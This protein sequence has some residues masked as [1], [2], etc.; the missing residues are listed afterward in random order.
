[1]PAGRPSRYNADFARMARALSRHGA[2]AWDLARAFSVSLA[3]FY[4]WRTLHP[5]FAPAIAAGA[6]KAE[7]GSPTAFQRARGYD[8]IE[9]RV[10]R[11]D[12]SAP[13]EVAIKRRVLASP[14]AAIRWLRN[15][16]PDEWRIPH[17]PQPDLLGLL[18]TETLKALGS[19]CGVAES[20]HADLQRALRRL[21][22]EVDTI[23]LEH[24]RENLVV[25]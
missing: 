1:M 24:T 3:T 10:F 7:H 17:A 15:R 13:V 19:L 4:R 14:G 21:L 22:A 23:L 9:R 16:R 11:P 12:S 2:D 6:A 5:E 8:R 18:G 25:A 20:D